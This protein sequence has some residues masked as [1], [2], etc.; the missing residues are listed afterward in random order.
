MK[1]VERTHTQNIY[2]YIYI[3]I[4]FIYHS[5]FILS[6]V[7]E[8]KW[9]FSPAFTK[10]LPSRIILYSYHDYIRAWFKFMLHQDK[11]MTHSWFVNFNKNFSSQLPLWF[12]QWWTQFGHITNIFPRSLIDFFKYFVS[13]YKRNTHGAKFPTILH[14][15]KKYK[16][17]WVLKWLYVKDGNVRTWQWFVKWWDKFSHIEDVIDNVTWEFPVAS[18]ST[19]YTIIHVKAQ[20]QAYPLVQATMPQPI[21]PTPTTTSTTKPAKSS[22]KTKKKK[23]A[24]DDLR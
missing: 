24:F 3:Y 6:I 20:A 21:T 19:V 14:F 15:V 9:G 2:I 16:V 10:P 4:V 23:S 8:K 18:Q 11:T 5:V 13:V 7:T 22:A 12:T 1:L 17:P